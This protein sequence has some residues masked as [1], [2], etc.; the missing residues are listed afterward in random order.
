MRLESRAER[1]LI[2]NGRAVGVLWR[3]KAGQEQRSYARAEVI[4]TAGALVT[5]KLLMLSGIG[6]ADHLREHGIDVVADLPGVGQNLVDHPE[7][8]II[9]TAN[10]QYGYFNQ[11][12]G[13]RMVLNGLQFK[14][15]RDRAA[16]SRR[17]W[18]PGPSSTP[19]DPDGRAHD[20]GLLRAD[21]L[22]RPRPPQGHGEHPRHDH[23]HRRGEAQVARLR[24]GSA[25]PTP[26][27]SRSSARTSSRTPRTC[28]EMIEGQRFFLRVFDTEPVE[29]RIKRGR[30]P[31]PAPAR[32]RERSPPIAAAWSRPT[33][34]RPA[35]ARMGA[36]GDPMAVLDARM[37]VRGI[38]GLRVADMSACPDINAGNTTAPALMLGSRCADFV[39]G[40][41]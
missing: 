25:P 16:S 32:R 37:R 18:R 41:E 40:L 38:E 17:A 2:E 33:T 5:P 22:S 4:L 20:P 3:D 12:K 27:T 10:G 19:R 14:A 15:L 7:V 21:R 6:P 24:D 8:P 26:P 34:T 9:A 11:G 31:R 29:S 30:V 35:T 23:H 13:W 1:V 28:A 39:M 36:D